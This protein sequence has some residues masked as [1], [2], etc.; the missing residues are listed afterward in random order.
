VRAALNPDCVLLAVVQEAVE[1]GKQ[2]GV[3]AGALRHELAVDVDHGIPIDTLERERH[4]LVAVL[5][6]NGEGLLEDEEAT[7]EESGVRAPAVVRRA[8]EITNCVVTSVTPRARRRPLTLGL[9][10]VP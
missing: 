5:V 6:R 3:A 2:L 10:L 4:G 8:G 1:L 7:R 9:L